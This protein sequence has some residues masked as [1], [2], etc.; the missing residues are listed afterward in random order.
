[1]CVSEGEKSL[2]RT[3]IKQGRG[4]IHEVPGL[5]VPAKWRQFVMNIQ[6]IDPDRVEAILLRNGAHSVT[7]TDAG[8]DPVLE[9]APGETPLWN[10]TNVT[11]LFDA[12]ADFSALKN[13]LL[14]ALELDVLP[15]NHVETLRDRAWER[16]WLR[17]FGPMRFGR[18]LWVIPGDQVDPPGDAIVVR[19]D[20][21]LAF[22]TG[23][24]PT[25]ALCLEWL[26]AID[27]TGKRVLDFGCG[28]GV[29]SVAACKLGAAFVEGIDIDLQAVAASRQ[30]AER[31]QVGD[32]FRAQQAISND[33][34]QFDI[35][36]A[37]ILAGTLIERASFICNAVRSGGRLALSGV[38]SEQVNDVRNAY[39]EW[40]EFDPPAIKDNWTRIT[41]M[42]L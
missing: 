39:R 42:R 29:L 13:D 31:N 37:N 28:S 34:G 25:T 21:G 40:V 15:P 35:V 17:D 19:L 16:E 1:M 9:P 33:L 36:V 20:P 11:G 3:R 8:D 14:C 41:G 6:S 30:N 38:L 27:L 32:Q 23:T 5:V 2:V 24:H 12:D 22:G 7:L 26:D 18:R 10:D 4:R